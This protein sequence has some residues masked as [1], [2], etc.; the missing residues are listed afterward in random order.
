MIDLPFVSIIVP[1][2]RR[3]KVLCN[4]LEYLFRQDYPK[5]EIIVVDQT[6]DHEKE[7]IEFLKS[8]KAK[9]RYYKNNSRGATVAKN[10]GLKFAKGKIILFIDD[11]VK[12]NCNLVSQHVFN[13][14]NSQ[15]G[16]V[17][18]RVV[19]QDNPMVESLGKKVGFVTK[20]GRFIDNFSSKISC[21]VMTVHG[22][23]ASFRKDLLMKIH[24][25]DENFT[26]NAFRE[27]SDLSFRVRRLGY[28]LIFDPKAEAIHLK[29]QGGSRDQD[30]ITWYEDFFCNEMLFFMKNLNRKYLPLRIINKIRPI[31]SC[32]F[33]YGKGKP[34]ALTAPWKGFIKGYKLY[35]TEIKEKSKWL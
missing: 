6:I 22:C 19:V 20:D 18:G 1:T 14:Q 33:Y 29:A 28:K 35:K 32:M 30:R 31:F 7:T 27:E 4:T 12:I 16:G 26:G 11:D 13:F 2:F 34:Q 5:Y 24:G 3:E 21:E 10:Y 25:F 23:N 9:I 8:N 15:I 17:A